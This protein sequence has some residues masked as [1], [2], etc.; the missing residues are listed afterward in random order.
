MRI[1]FLLLLF[2]LTGC[3][4]WNAAQM[5]LVT[6]AQRGIANVEKRSDGREEVTQQLAKLRR[7]RLDDAFDQDVRERPGLDADWVIEHRKAYCAAL[8]AYA[9]Q[10]Q[11][12]EAAI[13]A[14]KRDLEAVGLALQRLAWLQSIQNKFDI[15]S[16][17]FDAKH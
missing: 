10:Q 5:G 9:R 3:A 15:L 6:Q 14:E 4:Q 11:S 2:S 7:Q 13:V 12:E 16:E 17:V 1:S 8:D